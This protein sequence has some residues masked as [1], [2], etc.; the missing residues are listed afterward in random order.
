MKNP[1]QKA[2]NNL[3]KDF[4]EYDYLLWDMETYEFYNND[5]L[6]YINNFAFK[7]LFPITHNFLLI[8][9]L[10]RYVD[11]L[12]GSS[13]IKN[14]DIWK[15][16]FDDIINN[17][18]LTNWTKN[19]IDIVLLWVRKSCIAFLNEL[20]YEKNYESD[21]LICARNSLIPLMKYLYEITNEF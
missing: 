13:S 4:E 21:T 3:I 7:E 11:I 15:T 20:D 14:I 6:L 9:C 12:D 18:I 16:D 17:Y 2:I 8:V 5:F 1:F 19:E 10:I